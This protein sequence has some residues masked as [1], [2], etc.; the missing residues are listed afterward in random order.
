MFIKDMHYNTISNNSKNIGLS[1]NKL[2]NI[3]E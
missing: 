2:W 3:I 1:Q